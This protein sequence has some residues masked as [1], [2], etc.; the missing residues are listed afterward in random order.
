MKGLEGVTQVWCQTGRRGAPVLALLVGVVCW[1]P[2]QAARSEQ[3]AD[4]VT[5]TQLKQ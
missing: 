3:T 5:E 2:F 1:V 4:F